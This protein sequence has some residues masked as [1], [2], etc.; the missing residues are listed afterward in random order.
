MKKI[1]LSKFQLTLKQKWTLSTSLVI[2]FSYATI[3][4]IIYFALY[5]WLIHQE[6]LN[7][8]RTVDDL[9]DFFHTQGQ[10][11][12]INELKDN[13]GLLK[14][15]VHQ[16]QTVRLYNMDGYEVLRIN[17]Y[18]PSANINYPI[19]EIQKTVVE[20]LSL[21][22]KEVIVVNR[23][24][25]IGFF[26][27]IIQ[28][29]H[30]L[31]TFHSMMRYVL[32]V[33]IIAGIGALFIAVTMS[34]YLVHIIMKP[35]KDLRNSMTRV[36]EKGFQENIHFTYHHDDEIG[37]LLKIYRSMMNELE[38]TF[39][40]QQQFVSDASHELRTPI[41]AIEGHL[42]LIKR[43]G[44]DDPQVLEESLDL[45]IDE[46]Q[47]MKKMI[48]ELLS[49]ARNEG[50]EEASCD[51][52]KVLNTV[53]EELEVVYSNAKMNVV[54][55]G[56][57]RMAQISEN[58]F[59]QIVRNIIENGIRYNENIPIIQIHVHYFTE[60]IFM[61]IQDN[62][63]G[64]SREHLPFIFDRFY[65]VDRSRSNGG[66]TGLGLSISKMLANKYQ[67]EMDVSSSVGKGTT[68]TLRL[69]T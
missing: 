14:S 29:I 38:V 62:G 35:L 67:V 48:E 47:R 64:I 19:D 57:K 5:T 4:I 21:D 9:T 33:L 59:A 31:D 11:I 24:V 60:N 61:T 3:C 16:N 22:H 65:R 15:I 26:Q 32:T 13:T 56:E 10:S 66:G 51:I 30:P 36:K 7:A 45:A 17:D 23:L 34:H 12:S 49:L 63:I 40:R 54:F 46:V 42:S 44:K 50:K 27:G 55:D 53:I 69:P 20:K 2:F 8:V 37:D 52:E 58:A 39:M 6:E 18:S 25:Q 28:L 1:K 41:Q 68:F 43:W